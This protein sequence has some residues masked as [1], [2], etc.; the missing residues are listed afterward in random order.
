MKNGRA[1]TNSDHGGKGEEEKGRK[2]GDLLFPPFL[3]LKRPLDLEAASA[4]SHLLYVPMASVSRFFFRE[5]AQVI[6][7]NARKNAPA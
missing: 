5:N 2:G 1:V 7:Q 3:S 4:A 6:A